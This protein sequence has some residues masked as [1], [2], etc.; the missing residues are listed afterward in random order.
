M[1]WN[2]GWMGYGP[3]YPW[4]LNKN[5]NP[6]IKWYESEPIYI[7]KKKKKKGIQ[8]LLLILAHLYSPDGP[9]TTNDQ[10]TNPSTLVEHLS[11]FKIDLANIHSSQ[12]GPTKQTQ[13]I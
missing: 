6:I 9:D 12:V 13:I 4:H 3:I 2:Q 8:T 10:S 5:V 7:P 1:S 11:K